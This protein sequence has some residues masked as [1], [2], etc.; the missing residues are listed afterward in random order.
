MAK[1]EYEKKQGKEMSSLKRKKIKINN[2]GLTL[3]ELIVTFALL[4][5]FMVAASKVISDTVSIYYRAK[6]VQSGMQVSSIINTKISGEIESAL[7]EGSVADDSN[8]SIC[9]SEDGHK[10]EL[11]DNSGCHIYITN[12]VDDGESEGYMLIYYYPIAEEDEET[13]EIA[14]DEGSKWTFDK[15]AYMGYDIKELKFE[16]LSELSDTTDEDYGKYNGNMIRMTLTIHSDRYGDYTTVTYIE[17][18]N[19]KDESDWNRIKVK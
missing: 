2:D 12:K 7:K 15:K 14:V 10:I 3:I 4:G 1:S 9:I 16:K 8:I 6:G 18:Y 5:L 13:G 11:N 19:F 17:C